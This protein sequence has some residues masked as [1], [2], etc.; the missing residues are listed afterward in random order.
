[1]ATINAEP[2]WSP[3]RVLE[4]Q[5]LAR[6]GI[7]GNMNEQAKSLVERTEYLKEI[8]ATKDD[9]ILISG[10]L[11]AF[12]TLEIALANIS[13][14]QE[15]S[16]VEITNDGMNNGVYLWEGGKLTPSEYDPKELA[17]I[18]AKKY[19]DQQ[20]VQK[21]IALNRPGVLY[22]VTDTEGN[23]TWIQASNNDGM[24]TDFAKTAIRQ[25]VSIDDSEQLIIDGE[26][27]LYSVRDSDGN[28][29]AITLRSLDGQFASPTIKNIKDRIGIKQNKIALIGDEEILYYV[30]SENGPTALAV[31][32]S[33]GMLAQFV[34]DNIAQRL[35]ILPPE[36]EI[37]LDDLQYRPKPSD[38]QILSS[39]TRGIARHVAN[40]PLPAK[41][42]NFI[43]STNQ[44]TRLTFPNSYSDATPIILVICFE[45]IGDFALD[46]RAAYADVL[47]Y[48]VLWARC[49]FHGNHY[50][51]PQSMQ[52]ATEIYKK[53]CEIAPIAGCIIVG[54][55]MGGIAALNCLT[56]EV[57][58]NILGVYLTDPTY[59]L[60]Q[61]YDNGRADDINAAYACTAE[62]YNEK[63]KG[64]DPALKHWSAFKG[65]PFSI[66][67]TSNDSL[68][69]MSAHT[70]KLVEKLKFH[71]KVNVIDTKSGGHNAPEQFIASNLISFINQC[72]SGAVI[73]TI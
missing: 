53:A 1:M 19:A 40:K 55:S 17:I 46:I 58:P 26:P 50:G 49:D 3:V 8:S 34:I 18:A 2:N 63:T 66:V 56:N 12:S 32:K 39:L 69:T 37:N 24:P 45:G 7:N 61:R 57:V 38:F 23:Q 68:V 48:G 25:T 27:I 60:R 65:V 9:L 59:D 36:L 11:F 30:D 33:D 71:N 44:K 70:N 42:T 54:N 20:K 51:N 5:E 31:R 52:D 29:T 28:P 62:N 21:Y 22:E 72:A 16:K 10:G 67:A 35:N 41:I 43:N 73:T 64:Y 6:G 47:N 15:H 4:Q 13:K 14:I